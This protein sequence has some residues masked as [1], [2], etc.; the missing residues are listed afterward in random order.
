MYIERC[1][2]LMAAVALA[3]LVRT[4]L[5]SMAVVGLVSRYSLLQEPVVRTEAIPIAMAYILVVMV[6]NV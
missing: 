3:T 2:P 1:M 5:A 6:V 4:E